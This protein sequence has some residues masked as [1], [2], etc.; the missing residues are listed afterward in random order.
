LKIT[1]IKIFHNKAPIILPESWRPAWWEPDVHPQKTTSFAF[2]EV[3]TDEGITG[4]GPCPNPDIP[5]DDFVKSTLIGQDPFYVERFWSLNMAGRESIMGTPSLGGLEIA[6]WDIIGKKVGQ[7]VYKL[8]GACRDKVLA[9]VATAQLH[10]PKEHC[11]EAVAY[12]DRGVKAIKLR[13]HRPNSVDDLNVV[14]AVRDAV[15]DDMEI[16]VDANQ[17]NR[18]VNY[19][20]WSRREALRMARE[21]ERL[22]VFFLEE[23]LPLW[24]LEHLAEIAASVEMPIT[25]GEHLG[26][27]YQFRD[28]LFSGAFDIVQPDLVMDNIGI[29]GA[30]KIAIMADSVGRSIVPHVLTGGVSGLCIATTMQFLATV[31]N[32]PF[33]EY[34]LEPPALTVETQQKMLEEPLLIDKD[35]YVHVPQKPGIGVEIKEDVVEEYRR[36]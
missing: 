10:S 20:Y 14:K 2:Y 5:I 23:P 12:R 8:L 32:G 1:E 3:S 18:S 28:L 34:P 33:L 7:P 25:G 26:H 30:K 11:R 27:V 13:L 24:E 36:A 31:E 6:L 22:G 9:Y 15:G 21:L 16:L 19:N 4:I 29:T 35:G 17:N